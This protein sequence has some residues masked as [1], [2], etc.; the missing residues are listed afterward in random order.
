MNFV[1]IFFSSVLGTTVTNL[2]YFHE[3]AK[4]KLSLGNA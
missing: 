1:L 4:S 3:E 2:Y